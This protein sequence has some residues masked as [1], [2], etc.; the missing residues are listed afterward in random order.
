MNKFKPG[1]ALSEMLKLAITR[2]HGQFD[3]A[4]KPYFLHLLRVMHN[5][6]TDDEELQ[7][8]GIGHD[9]IEDT[10]TSYFELGVMGFSSRVIDG[11]RRMTKLPGQTPEEYLDII[12]QSIDAC[13]VKQA[14]LKDNSDITR[15]KGITDKDFARI[16]KY[17]WM[18]MTIK[19]KLENEWIR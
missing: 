13:K 16:K 11:I 3:K 5:L 10:D 19:A 18:Y 8:I 17:H 2:H 1:D 6:N 15:L 14:D 4:E 7:C 9:L 12:L